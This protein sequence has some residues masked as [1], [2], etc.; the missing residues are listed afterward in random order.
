MKRNLEYRGLVLKVS[1]VGEGHALV[2]FFVDGQ[3]DE[4]ERLITAMFYGLKKSKKNYGLR[5]FQ[6]GRVWFY[7]NPVNGTYKVVDFQATSLRETLSESLVRIWAAG[8][9][10]ELVF[11]FHGNCDFVLVNGFLDGIALSNDEECRFAL[12]RF[13]TRVL[14]FSGVLPLAKTCG[15]CGL[16]F[17]VTGADAYTG[18]Q[19]FFNKM[20]YEFYCE[21]CLVGNAE[22]MAELISLSPEA[23]NF[24][25]VVLNAPTKV[26]RKIVLSRFA[27]NEIRSFLF[28]LLQRMVGIMNTLEMGI[29]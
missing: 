8:F 21:K 20:N 17:W 4:S 11:K 26:S 13:V 22:N 6:T 27:E 2:S 1:K 24:L 9:A 23:Q 7:F 18:K 5:Q 29:L 25:D 3:E 28:F 14:N 10:C 15:V 16:E 19:A 12:L